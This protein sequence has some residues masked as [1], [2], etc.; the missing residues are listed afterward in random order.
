MALTSYEPLPFAEASFPVIFHLDELRQPVKAHWHDGIELLF[1]LRGTGK[2]VAETEELTLR[3]GE[4]TIINSGVLHY[5][6]FSP[7]DDCLYYCLIVDPDLLAASPL[8]LGEKRLRSQVNDPAVRE[9]YLQIVNELEQRA[10]YYK[11]AAKGSITLLFSLLFRNWAE[12]H[13]PAANHSPEMVKKAI[14]FLQNNFKENLSIDDV[15]RH[16]GFSKFYFCRCFRKVTGRSVLEYVQDLRC[17][18]AREL[19]ESDSCTVSECAALCGFSDVSYFTKV[20][21][22]QTGT[23]PSQLRRTKQTPGG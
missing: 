11:E 6:P 13:A 3:P 20:F 12:D 23:L 16:V 4:L 10:P 5:I 14:L 8:P 9:I 18:H 22:R 19:L 1:C 21:K 2:V 17:A 7:G 15:C